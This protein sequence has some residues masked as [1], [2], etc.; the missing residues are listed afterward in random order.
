MGTEYL[1]HDTPRDARPL[2]HPD[3]DMRKVLLRL[4][5]LGP[6][7]VETLTPAEAR[8]QPTPADAVLSILK[9]RGEE[10]PPKLGVAT[11]DITIEGA[12]G[13]LPAR[14]YRP[15][16]SEKGDLPLVVYFHGGGWVFADL[17]VY[18]A[19]PRAMA[20][21]A[22][23]AVLSCHY[24]QAPEHKFPA[25]HDDA[26]AAY[27]WALAHAD[28][29]GAD[30]TKVAVMGESAGG[31]LALNVAIR[32][33]DEGVTAPVHMAL[34]YPVAGADM[35]NESYIA[36]ADAKPLNKAVMEWFARHVFDDASQAKDARIDLVNAD[37][38][39]LPSATV[40]GA[41]ID[42]LADEGELLMRRLKDAGS[43]VRGEIYRG[44][45]HEFFG[46]GLVVKDAAIAESFVAHEL[47]HAFGTSSA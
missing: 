14:L 6:K 42:P 38:H 39:G 4:E 1:N 40:I 21:F 11:R 31:N 29:L 46:M 34:I 7:P 23:C 43:D 24:R 25:A 8:R 28:D 10:V 18:D 45:T 37:L 32:A 16:K 5:E 19:S 44:C 33:R 15:E 35:N 26:F 2:D 3:S 47:K 22:D 9:E 17:D 12:T 27:Q 20:R 13:P 36:N 41:E 30:S